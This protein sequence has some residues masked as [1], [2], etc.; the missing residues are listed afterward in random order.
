MIANNKKI[1]NQINT[2]FVLN[3]IFLIESLAFPVIEDQ[4]PTSKCGKND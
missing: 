1:D 2:N 3:E 4:I